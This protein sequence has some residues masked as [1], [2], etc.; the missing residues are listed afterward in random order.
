MGIVVCMG[1]VAWVNEHL[2]ERIKGTLGCLII[3][4]SR[5]VVQHLKF[6]HW[7]NLDG[8][9]TPSEWID[10]EIIPIDLVRLK[11]DSCAMFRLISDQGKK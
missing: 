11:E 5:H 6:D 9:N 1:I 3:T 7:F 10:R 4:H 2:R 8:Y